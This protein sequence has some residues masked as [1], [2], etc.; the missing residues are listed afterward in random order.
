MLPY[1][2]HR[3]PTKFNYGGGLLP[4]AD[5]PSP[6]QAWI[7]EISEAEAMGDLVRAAPADYA[8]RLER[9]GSAYF[10]VAPPPVP[11]PIIFNRVLGLGLARPA[12]RSLVEA[13]A[14]FYR[15]AGVNRWA[16]DLG[17]EAFPPSLPE[18]LTEL[19]YRRA[20]SHTKVYRRPRRDQPLPVSDYR[21]AQVEAADA[22]I[23]AALTGRALGWPEGFQ[24]LLTASIGR[25]GWRHY[26]VYD[27]DRPIA[28]GAL[29][30]RTGSGWLGLDGLM[31]GPSDQ[32]AR[33]LLIAHRLRDAAGLG[34]QWVAAE[35]VIQPDPATDP[36]L[37]AGFQ[38]AYQQDRYMAGE[39]D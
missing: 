23:Y 32:A 2:S 13:I 11:A 38:I 37:T 27:G 30:M 34:V 1:Y 7:T 21:V 36:F 16:V 31:G 12:P 4:G 24:A 18:W 19:G 35:T 29:F 8:L 5:L 28:S 25:L 14:S 26:L 39:S 15:S 9:S 3:Y 10:L 6:G 17:A 33:A 20:A 22:P